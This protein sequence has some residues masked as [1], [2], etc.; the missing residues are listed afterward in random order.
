M[1]VIDLVDTYAALAARCLS[2]DN[3]LRRIVAKEDR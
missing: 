2:I 3:E 1:V